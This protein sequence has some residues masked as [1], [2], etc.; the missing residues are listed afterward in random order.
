MA[1]SLARRVLILRACALYEGGRH[2]VATD[3]LRQLAVDSEDYM[4]PIGVAPRPPL[5]WRILPPAARTMES[6]V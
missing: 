3:L 6:T 2:A 5:D 4:R 1:P